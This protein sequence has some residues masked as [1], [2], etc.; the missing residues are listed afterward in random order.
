MAAHSEAV[1]AADAA[2]AQA[3]AANAATSE[4]RA[5][6]AE[7]NAQASEARAVTAETNAATSEGNAATSATNAHQ[8]ELNIQ[9]SE[10]VCQTAEQHAAQSET[11][12]AASEKLAESWAHGNTGVR[13]GEATDNAEYWCNQAQAIAGAAVFVG[14]TE[15]TNGQL[16]FVPGPG[17]GQQNSVLFGDATFKKLNYTFVGSENDWN[18]MTA[19]NKAFYKVV[20][21]ED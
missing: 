3:A 4:T 20:V 19:A 8:S 18:G 16:G 21:L 2:A 12:A 17:K 14:A 5:V 10:Q 9:G 1:V 13:P 11:N 7:T 6:T 15:T